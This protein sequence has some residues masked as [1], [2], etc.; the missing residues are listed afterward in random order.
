[1][2]HK[3]LR[4]LKLV[5]AIFIIF[6]FHQMIDLQKL[7]K[8]LF[9][10]YK[11]L[12]SL[13]RYSNFCISVLASF[14]TCQPLFRGWS[15]INLK[16][17][18]MISCLNKNLITHFVWYLENEKRCDTETLSVEYQ[19]KIIFKEKSCKNCAAKASPGLFYNLVNNTKQPLHARNYFK[20]KIFW[21]RII[22]KP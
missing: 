17:H 7:W 15:K 14:S 1:M 10:Y 5:S 12:F 13:L 9:S 22:K 4:Y 20:S 8:T 18:D 21:E 16:V 19:I 6:F 3:Y 2:F 11:K